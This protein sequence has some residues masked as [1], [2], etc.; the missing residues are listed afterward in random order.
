M[1]L[2]PCPAVPVTSFPSSSSPGQ[3]W[4]SLRSMWSVS[5][6][7][8]QHRCC[9]EPWE[10][11]PSPGW[12][13]R[14]SCAMLLHRGGESFPS[15]FCRAGLLGTPRLLTLALTPVLAIAPPELRSHFLHLPQVHMLLLREPPWIFGPVCDRNELDLAEAWDYCRPVTSQH[16]PVTAHTRVC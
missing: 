9:S 10:E 15:A 6:G 11:M 16:V 4:G 14:E 5:N 13:A 3:C 1:S 8:A 2:A 7:A 12:R